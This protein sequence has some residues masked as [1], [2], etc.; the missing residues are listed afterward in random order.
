VTLF[1]VGV[2]LLTV[3][4]LASIIPAR[5]STRIDPVQALR[6]EG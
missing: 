2:L 6:A 1:V 4:A 3:A 5:S